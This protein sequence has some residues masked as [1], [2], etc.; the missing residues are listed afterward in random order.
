M[1]GP[2]HYCCRGYGDPVWLNGQWGFTTEAFDNFEN[3]VT[4]FEG[5]GSI[6]RGHG[7]RLLKRGFAGNEYVYIS[8]MIQ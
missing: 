2:C 1:D 4:C 3:P 5:P 6:F 8:I 7:E